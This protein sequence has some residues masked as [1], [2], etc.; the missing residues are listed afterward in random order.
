MLQEKER[1]LLKYKGFRGDLIEADYVESETL[2][3]METKGHCMNEAK[4]AR[5][6]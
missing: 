2:T 1:P 5:M 3:G 6:Q 4:E